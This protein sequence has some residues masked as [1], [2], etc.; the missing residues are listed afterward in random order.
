MQF[1][2]DYRNIEDVAHNRRPSRLPLYEHLI[3][4][5]SM[6]KIAGFKFPDF[7]SG[8]AADR[9]QYF[10]LYCNF[11]LG[12]TYDTVSYEFCVTDILPG[13][14]ALLG[15]C[16][17]AIQNRS[18]FEKYPWPDLP[19]LFWERAEARFETLQQVI[20]D[21]MKVVG[22]IGNG[23][24]EIS[25][26]LVGFEQLCYMQIDD[27]ELFSDLFVRI[28]D[29]L[30]NLWSHILKRFSDLFVVCRSGDDMGFKTG[31]L[32]APN[33]ITTHIVPEYRRIIDLIH[34]AGK[35]FLLHSC[36]NIFEVMDSLIDAGI[37]GKHSNEDAICP[38]EDWISRYGNRIGLFGGI[39]TDLLCRLTPQD[40]YELVVER[41]AKF[42][43]LANGYA[44][45]SGN[46][47]PEYVP[48]E[49]YLAMIKAVNHLN[50]GHGPRR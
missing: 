5:E 1:A 6:E 41:G 8:N 37:N 40:V 32:L 14:G 10:E 18:D 9:R 27:P 7:D 22:G 25:E 46:S 42:R 35:P 48:T 12:M 3:N 15:E 2:P 30:I 21:G 20:P 36:G 13:G 28:G 26:D 38:F 23:L 43:E 4:D 19:R 44:I 47:I 33:T 50:R 31:T 49:N 11:F 17:G 16:A 29:L 34:K 24:F 45:G 39:D